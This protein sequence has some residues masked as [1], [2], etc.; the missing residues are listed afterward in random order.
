MQRIIC[1]P[2][3]WKAYAF[4]VYRKDFDK[5]A[6]MRRLILVFPACECCMTSFMRRQS[7]DIRCGFISG[8]RGGDKDLY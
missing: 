4:G 6:R 8:W 5:T 3:K 7:F 1:V 2:S